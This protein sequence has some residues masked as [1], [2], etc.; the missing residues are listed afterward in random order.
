MWNYLCTISFL[1]FYFFYVAMAAAQTCNDRIPSSTPDNRF[2]DNGDGTITDNATGLM[3]K[4]CV[5]GLSGPECATG[6]AGLF[7]WKEALALPGAVNS[8]SGFAGYT[9]WRLPNIKEL[10][11]LV[12]LKCIHPAINLDF[13]PNPGLLVWSST[14]CAAYS[15]AA[16][17]ADFFSGGVGRYG[18][19]NS[20]QLRL[21]RGGQ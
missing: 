3:W 15:G 21:V 19:H 18:R 16:W 2:T 7:T 6:T 8:G 14:P 12:E 9:D 4:Q 1:F 17:V 11:S 10:D 13:F 20:Y 5:E